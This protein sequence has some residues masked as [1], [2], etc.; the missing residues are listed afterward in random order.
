MTAGGKDWSGATQPR[1]NGTSLPCHLVRRRASQTGDALVASYR[2]VVRC[3]M[4]R[5]ASWLTL[6]HAARSRKRSLRTQSTI[7][8]C[9]DGARRG[10]RCRGT[11]S[12]VS[13]TIWVGSGNYA[14]KMPRLAVAHARSESPS[15]PPVRYARWTTILRA[16]R[17]SRPISPSLPRPRLLSLPYYSRYSSP[18]HR[19]FGKASASRLGGQQRSPPSN[20]RRSPIVRSMRVCAISQRAT[21]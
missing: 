8:S 3:T 13:A 18:R 9:V 6:L 1:H 12:G 4:R 17:I 7:S 5:I 16:F 2:S 10:R 19:S 21:A 15:L 20:G 14:G 11:R